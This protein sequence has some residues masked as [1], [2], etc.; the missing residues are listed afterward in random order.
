MWMKKWRNGEWGGS[1]EGKRLCVQ[2]GIISPK[3]NKPWVIMG[4]ERRKWDPEM[5]RNDLMRNSS[6]L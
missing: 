3:E 6:L 4:L 5:C 1:R 2:D